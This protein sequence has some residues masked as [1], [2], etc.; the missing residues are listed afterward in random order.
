[1]GSGSRFLSL[2]IHH[3]KW[4]A[5]QWT[6]GSNLRVPPWEITEA[7]TSTLTVNLIRG[8]FFPL[9]S[10]YGP[11]FSSGFLTG[12]SMLRHRKAFGGHIGMDPSSQISMSFPKSENLNRPLM[13]DRA[14]CHFLFN[15]PPFPPHK[16][17][18]ELSPVLPQSVVAGSKHFQVTKT[19]VWE[20]ISPETE[21]CED[22]AKQVR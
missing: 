13:W 12:T 1:M 6:W 18:T 8:A 14:S 17:K 3:H 7:P 20:S 19:I 10:G 4:A 16:G 9:L 22:K 21:S 11:Q 5:R 15:N 2:Q